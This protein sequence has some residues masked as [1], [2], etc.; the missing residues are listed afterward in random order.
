M[1]RA[2]LGTVRIRERHS[3]FEPRVSVGDLL[4]KLTSNLLSSVSR[5]TV[6]LSIVKPYKAIFCN[7]FGALPG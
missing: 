2:I 1:V 6:G 3:V 4:T 5:Q 7:A